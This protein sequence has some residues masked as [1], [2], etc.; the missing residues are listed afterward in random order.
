MRRLV[1]TAIVATSILLLIGCLGKRAG[2]GGKAELV[3]IKVV[4]GSASTTAREDGFMNTVK[5]KY[6]AEMVVVDSRYGM[7][8]R[9]KSLEVSENLLTANPGLSGIFAANEPGVVGAL[10]AV[11]ARGLAKKI[12]I[13]GFDSSPSLE[14]GVKDGTIDSLVVQDPFSI[15]YQAVETIADVLN[16]KTPEKRIPTKATL[17][18]RENISNSEIQQLLHPDINKYLKGSADGTSDAEKVVAVIP[19]SQAHIFWQTVHA[20][21]IAAGEELGVKILWKAP[22]TETDYAEQVR[23]IEDFMTQKVDG[24]VLAP[25]DRKALVPYIEKAAE[26]GIPLTIFDSGADTKKYVSFVATDNYQG[27]V[28]AAERM[29]EILKAK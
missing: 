13:V 16:G 3:V 21:A 10:E 29:A 25:T 22:T 6:A 27:G 11:K 8:D 5:E 4:P 1:T 20:G 28:M 15:G 14:K 12:K 7:S 2:G 17:I 26:Q 23:I 18:T 9:A 24:I 19:K